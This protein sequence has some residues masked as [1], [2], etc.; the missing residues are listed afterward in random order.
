MVVMILILNLDYALFLSTVILARIGNQ[1]IFQFLEQPE[2][3]CS[4]CGAKSRPNPIYPMIRLK[5]SVGNAR[6]E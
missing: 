3:S 4:Y 5:V 2:V 6:A 1:L